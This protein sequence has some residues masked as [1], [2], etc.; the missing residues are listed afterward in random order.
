[1]RLEFIARARRG[2][3]FDMVVDLAVNGKYLLPV[4]AQEWLCTGI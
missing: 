1:M 2:S 3:Q 4:F